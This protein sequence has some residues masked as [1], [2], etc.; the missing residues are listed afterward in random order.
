MADQLPINTDFDLR[1]ERLEAAVGRI[2]TLLLRL[3]DPKQEL[4]AKEFFTTGEVAKLLGKR[5]F[6]V[7]EWCR[8]GRVH[9]EKTH[10]GRGAEPEWRISQ[11]EIKRIQEEGLLPIVSRW[12]IPSRGHHISHVEGTKQ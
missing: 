3:G 11:L 5:P 9:A 4:N 10:A 8:L 6:T 1:L 2:E 12:K 7:R